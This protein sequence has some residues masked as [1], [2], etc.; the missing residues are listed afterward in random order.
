MSL[1]TLLPQPSLVVENRPQQ[2]RAEVTAVQLVGPPPYRGR[3]GWVSSYSSSHFYSV[4]IQAVFGILYRISY[5]CALT[6]SSTGAQDA[7]GLW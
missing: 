5:K 2:G 4:N 6:R 7:L 1:K 3:E